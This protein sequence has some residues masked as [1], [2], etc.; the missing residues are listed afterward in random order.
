MREEEEKGGGDDDEQQG[1]REW[2]KNDGRKRD[3]PRPRPRPMPM[4]TE[5]VWVSLNGLF[6][7][8]Y[9]VFSWKQGQENYAKIDGS[10][11]MLCGGKL[12]NRHGQMFFGLYIFIE[13]FS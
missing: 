10:N 2:E 12:E 7:Y 6:I 1:N 4:P 8:S 9:V 13:S 11:S 3:K 5:C